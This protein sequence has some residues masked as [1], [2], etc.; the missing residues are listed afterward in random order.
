M[1]LT[2]IK[3]AIGKK[4]VCLKSHDLLKAIEK[5]GFSD[6]IDRNEAA[7]GQA[8]LPDCKLLTCLDLSQLDRH[9]SSMF[10]DKQNEGQ[11]GRRALPPLFR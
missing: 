3:D 11:S 6:N 9:S 7:R 10:R 1:P 2:Y 5:S 4:R 8:R